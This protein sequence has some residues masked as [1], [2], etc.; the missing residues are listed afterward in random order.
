MVGSWRKHDVD[1]RENHMGKC[2]ASHFCN[3]SQVNTFAK[4]GLIIPESYWNQRFK[5]KK[6]K[7][8]ICHRILLSS[9][10]QQ[11]ILR[12]GKIDNVCKIC[13]N[14]TCTC[15]ACKTVVFHRQICKFLVG[16]AN[17]ETMTALDRLGVYASLFVSSERNR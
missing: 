8:N 10:Q 7:M 2:I 4:C 14:E 17:Q 13:K 15:K 5:G 16:R 11:V 3:Y 9:T 12:R 1:D 6:T